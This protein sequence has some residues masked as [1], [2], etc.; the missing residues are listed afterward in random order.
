MTSARHAA[1]ASAPLT[2]N[3]SEVPR[4]ELFGSLTHAVGVVGE[5]LVL[6]GIVFCIPFV[7]LG[8]GIPIALAVRFLLWVGGV[9]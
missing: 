1:L 2:A 8:I 9:L 3:L 5:V 6:V 4:V 7:V